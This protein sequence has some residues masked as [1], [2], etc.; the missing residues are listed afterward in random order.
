MKSSNQSTVW[1]EEKD[2][3]DLSC[4]GG[5]LQGWG[6][7][8]TN[9]LALKHVKFYWWPL[10][11]PRSLLL[12]LK[13]LQAHAEFYFEICDSECKAEFLIKPCRF[14]LQKCYIIG[15]VNMY[16]VGNS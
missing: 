16:G 11:L 6:V 1:L 13:G 8:D 14:S 5:S 4:Q 12:C 2:L 3:G 15:L 7:T 9:S 10:Q